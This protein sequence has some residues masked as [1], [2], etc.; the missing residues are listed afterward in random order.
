MN[1]KM[2]ILVGEP[3]SL[4]GQYIPPSYVIGDESVSNFNT[5]ITIYIFV[6]NAPMKIKFEKIYFHFVYL[7]SGAPPF[8]N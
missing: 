6:N 4:I 2:N 7:L 1:I 3:A 5:I 8:T